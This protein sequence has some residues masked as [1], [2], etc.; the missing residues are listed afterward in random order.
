[1][2]IVFFFLFMGHDKSSFCK[3]LLM[4]KLLLFFRKK[5]LMA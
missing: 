1:M 2:G 4:Q 5:Q 3:A